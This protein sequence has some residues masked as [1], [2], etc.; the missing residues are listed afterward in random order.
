DG[1]RDLTVTG[2]QTCAL[3]IWAE[4]CSPG[5]NP[6]RSSASSNSTAAGGYPLRPDAMSVHDAQQLRSLTSFFAG[7]ATRGA[8][9]GDGAPGPEIGRASCRE[10]AAMSGAAVA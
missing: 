5:R 6:R 7:L 1:I 4:S 8:G 3:P 2:V 10:R 9:P